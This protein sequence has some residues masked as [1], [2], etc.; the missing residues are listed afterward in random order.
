MLWSERVAQ[1]GRELGP[2]EHAEAVAR[3]I[4][5]LERGPTVQREL[6]ASP[7]AS[8]LNSREPAV[9]AAR[10]KLGKRGSLRSPY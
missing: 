2:T 1:V 8:W 6:N 9:L 7:L 3:H 5:S 10:R 4:R